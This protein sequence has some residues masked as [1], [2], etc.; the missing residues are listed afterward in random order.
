MPIADRFNKVSNGSQA[1]PTTLSANKAALATTASL[2]AATGWDVTTAKHIRVYK[3]TVVNGQTVVDTTKLC[4]Y[5]ATLAG[6]TLS[7]VTLVWSSTGSDQAFVIGDSV[8]QG[9]TT[10]WADDLVDGIVVEHKQTG[11]HAAVTADSVT[12]TGTVQGATVIATGDIQHRSVSLETIRSESIF[13]HIAS[14]CVLTGTG[15]GTTLAW[16]LTAGVVY[17][18]GKRLTVAAAT[19]VVVATKDTYFDLL[20]PGSGTVATLVFTGVNSG[21]V[22]AAS[23][24][25]AAN[26]IRIGIIQSGATI[27]SVASVNQGQEDKVLPIASS[28]PYQVT[29]SLGNLICPRDPNRK[30]LGYR[31]LQ[32]AFSTATVGAYVDVTSLSVPFIHPTAGRKVKASFVGT[33]GNTTAGYSAMAVREGSTVIAQQVTTTTS[34]LPFI[35]TDTTTPSAGLHTYVASVAANGGTSNIQFG[36]G[37]YGARWPAILK[38]ELE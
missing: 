4:Y 27:V 31:R 33:F 7:N 35:A 2:N 3:T 32:A 1:L 20:D 24:A 29:D 21:T 26:S 16:N 23:P 8:D 15:Y 28:I 10:R 38:I 5:K 36:T 13:D 11:A 12:A 9:P 6:T 22:N 14:G 17:D 37:A 19:G 34:E 25:L 30:L 18:N